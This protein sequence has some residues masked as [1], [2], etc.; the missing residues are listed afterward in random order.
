MMC[1]NNYLVFSYL[2]RSILSQ[3]AIKLYI[4][5]KKK[6]L[7]SVIKLHKTAGKMQNPVHTVIPVIYHSVNEYIPS[8]KIKPVTCNM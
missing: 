4:E 5:T 1:Y 7:A 2:Y 8:I 6:L 3:Y